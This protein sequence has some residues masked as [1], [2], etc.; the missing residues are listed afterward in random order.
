MLEGGGG[1]GGL[2]NHTGRV[3]YTC[4]CMNRFG[5]GAGICEGEMVSDTFGG[6]V[7]NFPPFSE[8]RVLYF[9]DGK[10]FYFLDLG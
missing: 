9:F 4:M 3:G 6:R 1:Y 2:T 10:T 8:P 5:E 7:F